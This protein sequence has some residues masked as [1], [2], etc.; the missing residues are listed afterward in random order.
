[1]ELA[2]TS[3]GW[4]P[5]EDLKRLKLTVP[6]CGA[7]LSN[8]AVAPDGSVVPCQSWLSA[9]PLGSIL[10]DEWDTIWNSEK[11]KKIR[12]ESA[13]M[14]YKCPLNNAHKNI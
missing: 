10:C 5:E 2:F 12:K 13:K 1:M 9:E 7:C 3:P 14:E 4:I 6:S 8:M 11:C